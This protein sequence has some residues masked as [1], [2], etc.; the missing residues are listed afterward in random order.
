MKELDKSKFTTATG[1]YLTKGL[2]LEIDYNVKFAMFTLRDDDRE[3]KGLKYPSLKKAYLEMQDPTE[4]EFATECLGSWSHWLQICKSPLLV[5]HI[6]RWREELELK[7]RAQGV[8][9]MI[10]EA[11]LGGRG[12]ASAARWLAERGFLP[13]G[14]AVKVGRPKKDN[15][16]AE[17]AKDRKLKDELGDDLKRLKLVKSD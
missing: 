2:F 5:P 4:Y 12:Q 1:K 11:T 17:I 10:N 16:E 3:Y 6:E 15:T 8:R 9:A 13:K 7:I 14:A